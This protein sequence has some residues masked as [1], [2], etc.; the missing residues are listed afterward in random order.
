MLILCVRL[1]YGQSNQELSALIRQSFSYFPRIKE[2]N[3]SSEL[4]ELQINL[5]QSSYLPSVDGVASYTYLSPLSQAVFP[6][7]PGTSEL[8]KFYPHNNYNFNLSLNQV[9]WDFGK[10]QAQIEKAKADLLVAHENT[11]SAKLQ[12][13][14]QVASVYYSLIYLKRSVQVQDSVIAYYQ[15]DKK[16]IEGK[17]KQG[18]ALQIDLSTIENNID[19]EKNRQ[20]EFQRLYDRQA[21]LMRY[22]TGQVAS[23]SAS[24]F[25][26]KNIPG[27]PDLANNPDVLAANERIA[28]ARANAKLAESNRLPT[29]NFQ[30]GAGLKNGYFPDIYSIQF[31][32][33]AGF[34]LAVPIYHGGRI[35][36]NISIAQKNLELNEISKE[37]ITTTLQKDLES[38]QSDRIAYE[39]QIRNSEGQIDVARETLRLTQVRYKQGVVT[40]LDLVNA[41]TDLQ[42]AYL[43]RLQ[44]EYQSTLSQVETCRLLGV[45]FW[46]E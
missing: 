30:A 29:L 24:D 31:N 3:K 46:Q 1:G 28:S 40:Y 6:T 9:V 32:Y 2:L 23:P 33:L 16:I 22:T 21:A 44:Y 18:D 14:A 8:L 43:N 13:A 15:D 12:L 20:V 41:S 11:E 39:Q 42:R 10:T 25:D 45:K 19:Q 36:Q 35:K 17:I 38:V 37:N 34:S 26:F 4:G 5:A 27:A 7:G